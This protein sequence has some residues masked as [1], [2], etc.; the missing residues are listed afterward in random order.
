MKTYH[1]STFTG[2]TTFTATLYDYEN[3]TC[4]EL[5]QV[6]TPMGM[7]TLSEADFPTANLGN[8]KKDSYLKCALA[9]VVYKNKHLT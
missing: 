5:I 6:S 3:G 9:P 2:A 7:K 4:S 8:A 1:A